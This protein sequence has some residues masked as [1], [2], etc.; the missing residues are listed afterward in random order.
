MAL[1]H[2]SPLRSLAA[3]ALTL[4]L[5]STTAGCDQGDGV[6]TG[7][8][9]AV[10][11][12][13]GIHRDETWAPFRMDLV[14]MGIEAHKD[15]VLVRLATSDDRV[16][17]TDSFGFLVP[18]AREVEDAIAA[19]GEATLAFDPVHVRGSLT[20]LSR[21]D[22]TTPALVATN[23]HV[24]LTRFGTRKGDRLAGTLAFDVVDE[25]TGEVVGTGFAG[26]FDFDVLHGLPYSPFAQRD[27]E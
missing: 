13:H 17:T 5:G 14:F 8:T 10:A 27:Y 11:N 3:I 19:S 26:E 18:S 24:T 25:R 2:A 15:A 22:V 7:D 21:C 9:L 6:I 12:C 16:D 23:G 4:A 1:M 20:L